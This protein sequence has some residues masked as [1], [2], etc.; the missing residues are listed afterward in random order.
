MS[1]KNPVTPQGIDPGTVRLVEQRLNHCATPGPRNVLAHNYCLRKVQ[2]LTQSAGNTFHDK[3]LLLASVPTHKLVEQLFATVHGMHS[4][5]P[6]MIGGNMTEH[7]CGTQNFD[8]GTLLNNITE[9]VEEG[10]NLMSQKY[11]ENV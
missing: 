5:P 8:W 6:C 9:R 1:L 7:K 2:C 10:I 11:T 4:G 3:K